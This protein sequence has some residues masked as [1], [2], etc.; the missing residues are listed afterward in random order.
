MSKLGDIHSS[1]G[2]Q[3]SVAIANS[4]VDNIMAAEA[5]PKNTIILSSPY[6]IENGDDLDTPAILVTDNDGEAVLLSKSISVRNGL[7]YSNDSLSMLIDNKTI[8]TKNG[9]LY[10]DLSL[11]VNKN[12]GLSITNNKL[13]V[14][15]NKMQKATDSKFGVVNVDNITIKSDN[16]MLYANTSGLDH[17]TQQLK[18]T[19]IGDN[20]T[21]KTVNGIPNVITANLSKTQNSYGIAKPDNASLK[22]ENSMLSVKQDYLVSD[23]TVG[24]LKVD[25]Q[26][27]ISN[28]GVLSIE[29]ENISKAS[30]TRF[31]VIKFDNNQFEISDDGKLTMKDYNTLSSTLNDIT[32][33][34]Q[35]ASQQ[36]EEIENEIANI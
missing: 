16:G 4:Y 5:L 26:G 14:D 2:K 12:N 6:D 10:V 17:A 20:T 8:T 13:S 11:F 36:V 7:L 27:I 29:T 33:R 34:V 32:S 35:T 15:P 24:M 23:N 19:V 25:G 22:I 21:I 28:A 3:F 30:E 18:G 31:G 1:F 9:K